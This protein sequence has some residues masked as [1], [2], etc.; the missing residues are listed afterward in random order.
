MT[1][2]ETWVVITNR[3]AKE[4]RKSQ[5]K[6][7][8]EPVMHPKTI[9]LSVWWDC[10]DILYFD[11]LLRLMLTT[12]QQLNNLRAVIQEKRPNLIKWNS[13]SSHNTKSHTS[14]IIQK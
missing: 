14:N 3:N 6:V 10:K 12:C 5:M 8:A 7:I 13:L 1:N 9:L 2:N 11:L 4:F